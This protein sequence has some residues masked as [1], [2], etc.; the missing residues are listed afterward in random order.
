[1]GAGPAGA[2]APVRAPA[3]ADR[4]LVFGA[5][6]ELPVA[7][8]QALDQATQRLRAAR[9]LAQ[10]ANFTAATR[11]GNRHRQPPERLARRLGRAD[12]M[13]VR[14]SRRRSLQ[15][16]AQCYDVNGSPSPRT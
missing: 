12:S 10:K 9:D 2:L 5:E 16:R 3:L 8:L 11:L 1:L 7:A 6:A 14:A 15:P 13:K 4:P